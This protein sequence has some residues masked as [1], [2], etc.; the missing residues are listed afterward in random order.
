LLFLDVDKGGD[1]M[2][3]SSI[4]DNF[5]GYGAYPL[6]ESEKMIRSKLIACLGELMKKNDTCF[7][8]ARD[9]GR[10]KVMSEILSVKKRVE[11]ITA[12]TEKSMGG[13]KYRLEV[14]SDK[15]DKTA[16][17]I[18]SRIEELISGCAGIIDAL[19]CSRADEDIIEQYS[20]IMS[21][22]AELEKLFHERKKIFRMMQV[23]G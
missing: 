18:D 6:S 19:T 10:E 21:N 16:S 13:I 3:N 11:R 7:E 12:E 23:Y 14:I 2:N 15:D 20:K 5:K 9:E 1:T 22:L 17:R 4:H 8:K